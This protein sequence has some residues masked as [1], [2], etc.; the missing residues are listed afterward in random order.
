MPRV[1]LFGWRFRFAI[2][3]TL[4]MIRAFFQT[5]SLTGDSDDLRRRIVSFPANIKTVPRLNDRDTSNLFI[6]DRSREG[7]RLCAKYIDTELLPPDFPAQRFIPE[8]AAKLKFTMYRCF[9]LR[10]I[11][12]GVKSLTNTRNKI[13][14]RQPPQKKRSIRFEDRIWTTY[15]RVCNYDDTLRVTIIIIRTP[16]RWYELKNFDKFYFEYLTLEITN[17]AN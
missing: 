6:S 7:T 5:H 14:W 13:M 17:L 10:R 11:F 12:I 15:E 16:P 8:I 9:Q 4:S 2:F 3:P 1:R